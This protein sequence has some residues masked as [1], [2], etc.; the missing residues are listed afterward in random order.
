MALPSAFQ[1]RRNPW[2]RS[3]FNRRWRRSAMFQPVL[4]LVALL[5]WVLRAAIALGFRSSSPHPA[6]RD[7]LAFRRGAVE[8]GDLAGAFRALVIC[9][10]VVV[11]QELVAQLQVT[12]SYLT[13]FL[14]MLHE[15]VVAPGALRRRC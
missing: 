1:I 12:A 9:A 4:M 3:P 5:M 6:S 10:L 7:R 15:S 8:G 13:D 11:G 2:T 14:E